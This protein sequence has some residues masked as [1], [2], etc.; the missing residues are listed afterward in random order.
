MTVK[1]EDNIAVLSEN[2]MTLDGRDPHQIYAVC[3]RQN[4]IYKKE[5]FA[6]I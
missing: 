2:L 1:F 3:S 6:K 5:K 4:Q